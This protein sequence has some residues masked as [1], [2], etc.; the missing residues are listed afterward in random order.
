MKFIIIGR[1]IDITEGLKS[2]VQEKLG[3]LERYFTPETEIHVTLSVEKDRQKI[4]VTIPVKGNIIR[5][6]QVSSDMYV[7][8]DLV[9]EV[10]E[11]QLRKYKTK[12]V[13]Q[14]QAGGNFQKEFVE[15]E[16]L[17]DEEVNIIRTKKFG[18]KPM[19]PEDACVQ[20]E[21]LGH[22]FYVF[23]NAE[24]DEVNVVYKRKGN[25]YGLIEPEC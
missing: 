14:Q 9:E 18:I 22:N 23:R 25:T 10:I 21:L 11:R 15:D 1:N 8:I 4:E 7:S 20:M 12:I 13:N 16:F 17:E 19:Y 24:T 2:A 6:E 5:S 3:K